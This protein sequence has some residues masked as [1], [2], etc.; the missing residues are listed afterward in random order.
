MAPEADKSSAFETLRAH[1]KSASV[2][3]RASGGAGGG[4]SADPIDVAFSDISE[5][6]VAAASLAEVF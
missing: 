2:G 4:G 3:E 1:L 5:R 6:P